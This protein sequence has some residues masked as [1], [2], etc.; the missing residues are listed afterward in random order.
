MLGNLIAAVG[1]KEG[2]MVRNTSMEQLIAELPGVASELSALRCVV[3]NAEMGIIDYPSN[4]TIGETLLATKQHL[5]RIHE[6]MALL[7]EESED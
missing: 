2:K 5:E 4:H 6:D 1:R 3:V 7:I